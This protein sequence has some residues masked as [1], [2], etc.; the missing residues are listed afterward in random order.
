MEKLN[1][2]PKFNNPEFDINRSQPY[3][4]ELNGSPIVIDTGLLA[5][6]ILTGQIQSFLFRP[7]VRPADDTDQKSY[8]GTPVFSN[9]I[10]EPDPATGQTGVYTDIKGIDQTFQGLRIDTVLFNVRQ[11]KNIVKTPVQGFNGTVK[12]YTSD[13]DYEVE[14]AGSIVSQNPDQYPEEDVKKL[15]DILGIPEPLEVTSEFLA[16]LGITSLVVESFTI[17]QEAG[18][19]NIQPFTITALSDRPLEFG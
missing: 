19:R 4:R 8:L 1:V 17:N 16:Y 13:G 6:G 15:L 7:D 18:Y 2:S 3:V 11:T 5:Q 9:L 12:E 10:F 14:I